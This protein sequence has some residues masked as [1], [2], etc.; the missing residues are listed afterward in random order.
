MDDLTASHWD[1]ILSPS[2][3]PFGSSLV[4][5]NGFKDKDKHSHD[6]DN[7]FEEEDE[8]HEGNT[9]EEHT[10]LSSNFDNLGIS[11]H[12]NAEAA[13]LSELAK[14]ERKDHTTSLMSELTNGTDIDE[15]IAPSSPAPKATSD[16]LFK[17]STSPIKIGGIGSSTHALPIRGENNTFGKSKLF[18][19]SRR[20]HPK[21][22]VENLNNNPLGPLGG[23][24][25]SESIDQVDKRDQLVK[26]V[27]SPLYKIPKEMEIA[28]QE[29]LR[30]P[31]IPRPVPDTTN[32]SSSA[33]PGGSSN[34]EITVGDPMKIGDIT[35]AHIIYT[36]YVKN[37]ATLEGNSDNK[38][39]FVSSEPVSRRYRDF[40]WLYHQLQNNH[41]GYIIPP[42]PTKQTYIGR[43]NEN[44]IEN[45]RLSLEKMLTK[46]SNISNLCQDPDFIM[47]LKSTDFINE[48]KERD[49]SFEI[50]EENGFDMNSSILV[51]EPSG[52]TGF[53]NS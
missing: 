32:S 49:R 16:S 45:R 10:A 42:P 21:T 33:P 41:P 5:E 50:D 24:I 17:D 35:S 23:E 44:F 53:M 4:T 48:S 29:E 22:V 11:D 15:I 31:I 28:Q 47:F 51:D 34:L 52:S 37:R 13:Q 12:Y 3:N 6:E 43:F 30:H 39:K 9:T 26:E 38:D 40:R 2:S 8:R 25:L 36:I 14:E 7:T 27:E 18:A 46:I 20:F 19:R 1:D